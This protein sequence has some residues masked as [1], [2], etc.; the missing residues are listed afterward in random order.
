MLG[1]DLDSWNNL[2]LISLTI[3]ALAAVVLAVATTAVIRLQ[4]EE[5]IEA[6]VKIAEAN[7]RAAEASLATEQLRQQMAPRR[8][9]DHAFLK[10]LEKKPKPKELEILYLKDDGECFQLAMAFMIILHKAE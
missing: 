8:L 4:K 2:M 3:A 5:S 7:K 9:N 6:G 1:L 10:E